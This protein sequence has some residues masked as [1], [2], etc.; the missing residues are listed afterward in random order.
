M[1]GMKALVIYKSKYGSTKQYAEWIASS[2][3]ADVTSIKNVGQLRLDVYDTI[4]IGS[5]FYRG[6]IG[7]KGFLV[8]FWNQL[9]DKTLVLYCVTMR[10]PDDPGIK[11]DYEK[12]VPEHIRQSVKKFVLPGRII[13]KDMDFMDQFL[14]KTFLKHPEMDGVNKENILPLLE[15]VRKKEKEQ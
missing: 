6:K 13:Y 8:K 1:G 15:W 3:N 9:K 10:K 14:L 7:L 11:K 4:I 5:P 2:L 12:G